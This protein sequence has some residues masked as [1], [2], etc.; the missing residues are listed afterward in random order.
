MH[1]WLTDEGV[2]S[3]VC[4]NHVNRFLVFYMTKLCSQPNGTERTLLILI[5]TLDEECTR[6]EL[7]WIYSQVVHC[8]SWKYVNW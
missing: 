3:S 1:L 6:L 5:E 4:I 8:F 2:V 7:R